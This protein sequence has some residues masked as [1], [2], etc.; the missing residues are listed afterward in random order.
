MM[1]THKIAGMLALTVV[2]FGASTA[3]AQHEGHGQE[4][5][6]QGDM[7]KMDKRGEKTEQEEK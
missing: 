1:R 3:L 7:H 4:Q 2:W 5:H 6:K